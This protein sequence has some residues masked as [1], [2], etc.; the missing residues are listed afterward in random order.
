[1]DKIMLFKND[2]LKN[3]MQFN[4]ALNMLYAN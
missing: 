4:D 2:G 1:M 3:E